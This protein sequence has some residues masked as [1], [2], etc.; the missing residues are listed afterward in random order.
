MR[1]MAWRN[2]SRTTRRMG[3]SGRS[4][5][6]SFSRAP[7]MSMPATFTVQLPSTS[8]AWSSITRGSSFGAS[9]SQLRL[10]AMGAS[11]SG[12]SARAGRAASSTNRAVETKAEERE[13][14][15]IM[16]RM[17]RQRRRLR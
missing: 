17:V 9:W 11:G 5:A 14:M 3:S 1:S 16:A 6:S 12:S 2:S 8:P 15:G 4:A 7:S 10:A 13:G